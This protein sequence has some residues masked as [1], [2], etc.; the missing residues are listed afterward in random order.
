MPPLAVV[1]SCKFMG[2]NNACGVIVKWC[3][4]RHIMHIPLPAELVP[5]CVG[6]SSISTD[7][8]VQVKLA[9]LNLCIAMKENV[10]VRGSTSSLELSMLLAVLSR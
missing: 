7:D 1:I 9:T 10:C 4:D 8:V 2:S 6:N 3:L 5:F